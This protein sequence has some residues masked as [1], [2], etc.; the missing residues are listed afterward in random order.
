VRKVVEFW[1]YKKELGIP[2]PG[3]AWE[4]PLPLNKALRRF[5]DSYANFDG[6]GKLLSERRQ[7]FRIVKIVAT[8]VSYVRSKRA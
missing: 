8:G 2:Y 1:I 6:N 5:T 3:T 7:D 4:G